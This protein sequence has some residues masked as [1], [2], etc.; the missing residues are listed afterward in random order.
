MTLATV[1][2][3]YCHDFRSAHSGALNSHAMTIS[4]QMMKNDGR[5]TRR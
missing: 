5:L 3:T 4:V 2:M 1:W